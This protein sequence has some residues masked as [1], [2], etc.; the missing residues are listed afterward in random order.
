MLNGETHTL[1]NSKLINTHIN[2][3]NP[4]HTKHTQT[5]T[6]AYARACVHKNTQTFLDKLDVYVCCLF[7]RKTFV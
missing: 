7:K 6:P 3:P 1:T 5:L 2:T 4:T